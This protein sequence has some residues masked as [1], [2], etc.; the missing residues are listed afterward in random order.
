MPI[1]S[2]D[3]IRLAPGAAKGQA[4]EYL[5]HAFELAQR[6]PRGFNTAQL[7]MKFHPLLSK[8]EIARQGRIFEKK[9][10]VRLGLFGKPSAT[11]QREYLEIAVREF[12]Q[13]LSARQGKRKAP[14]VVVKNVYPN[15]IRLLLGSGA[16]VGS[17]GI[18]VALGVFRQV[19][20]SLGKP[21]VHIV[22]DAKEMGKIIGKAPSLTTRDRTNIKRTQRKRPPCH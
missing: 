13:A 20:E 9:G 2:L 5:R 19:N 21:A 8:D 17:I 11:V 18:N 6:K 12:L 10:N 15:V 4:M 14:F 3:E 22:R 1:E 16:N 7:Y